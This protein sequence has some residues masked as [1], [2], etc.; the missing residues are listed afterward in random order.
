MPKSVSEK[1]A[2]IIVRSTV[3]LVICAAVA[4]IILERRQTADIILNR[5]VHGLV[6]RINEERGKSTETIWVDSAI[7]IY[8]GRR[9]KSFIAPGDSIFK[10]KGDSFYTVKKRASGVRVKFYPRRY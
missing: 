7:T 4:G 3:I 2:T 9:V 5:E 6:V 8:T 10:E 1:I